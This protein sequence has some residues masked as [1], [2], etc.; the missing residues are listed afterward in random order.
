MSNINDLNNNVESTIMIEISKYLNKYPNYYKKTADKEVRP[1]HR[2]ISDCKENELTFAKQT[3]NKGNWY[4]FCNIVVEDVADLWKENHY[5]SEV[6]RTEEPIKCFFDLDIIEK[7]EEKALGY[8]EWEWIRTKLIY[9]INNIDTGVRVKKDDFV[10]SYS[11]GYSN[12]KKAI[13]V[14]YHIVILNYW[15]KNMVDFKKFITQLK[16]NMK[17]CS[18]ASIIIDM[19]DWGIV[20]KNQVFKLPYQSKAEDDNPDRIQKPLD[21]KWTVYDFLVSIR[22]QATANT[23]T[24]FYDVSKC[25]DEKKVMTI[26][27]S[28]NKTITVGS[29]DKGTT[30]KNYQSAIAKYRGDVFADLIEPRIKDCFKDSPEYYLYSI[31]NT[32]DVGYDLWSMVGMCLKTIYNKEEYSNDERGLELWAEWTSSYDSA[33]KSSSLRSQWNSFSKNGWGFPTIKNIAQL[34]NYKIGCNNDLIDVLFRFEK[35]PTWDYIECNTDKLGLAINVEEL[36]NAYNVLYIKSP[37]ATGKSYMLRKIYEREPSATVLVL[38][39]KRSFASSMACELGKYGF[40]NYD[41][42]EYKYNIKDHD[43]IICSVESLYHCRDSYDYLIIDE[44]ETIATNLVGEMNMKG[45]PIKNMEKFY[46]LVNNCKNVFVM[47][48]YLFNRSRDMI[49]DI[50]QSNVKSVYI[51]NVYKFPQRYVKQFL[52]EQDFVDDMDKVL[53]NKDKEIVFVSNGLRKQ[54][55]IL[56]NMKSKPSV[57]KYNARCP[58]DKRLDVNKEWEG[59]NL[60]TY[61]PTITAG[62]SCDKKPKDVLYLYTVNQGSCLLR[63]TIQASKRV[64]RFNNNNIRLLIGHIPTNGEIPQTYREVAESQN[65]FIESLSKDLNW[66]K[67]C[68]ENVKLSYIVK[69]LLWCKL[70]E[71]LNIKCF[72]ALQNRFFEEENIKVLDKYKKVE[73]DL[74]ERWSDDLELKLDKVDDIDNDEYNEICIMK[75]DSNV[76]DDDDFRK[77]L[78]YKYLN[79]DIAD[80]LSDE[81]K[82]NVFEEIGMKENRDVWLKSISFKKFVE[83]VLDVENPEEIKQK[84]QDTIMNWG[85]VGDKAEIQQKYLIRWNYLL[86]IFNDMG[87]VKDKRIEMK[88]I[89]TQDYDKLIEKFKTISYRSL[90]QIFDDN[91]LRISNV[92]DDKIVN[93]TTKQMHSIF[94]NLLDECLGLTLDK[95]GRKKIKGRENKIY[96]FK[97]KFRDI[98]KPMSQNYYNL[99]KS[100]FIEKKRYKIK[101]KSQS[102]CI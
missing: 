75:E 45:Y 74:V 58:L 61:T 93:F 65:N 19:I 84:I 80:G 52:R 91:N 62:V 9:H 71:N 73:K 81:V 72:H 77:Y 51:N 56:L 30:M 36:V 12:T 44:S 94:N 86:Q 88:P 96:D 87:F 2:A 68:E 57:L 35:K 49:V 20:K 18:K 60:L 31:P 98:S 97:P 6:I 53:E 37:M 67:S 89:L 70:E 10:A 24:V 83:T 66:L 54:E 32:V 14:S 78:K 46:H 100:K 33:I 22:G 69:I 76:L 79:V 85:K 43:R 8:Y 29:W 15:F 55:Q 101:R 34:H 82:S 17:G 38:S 4:S 92:I 11:R 40:E 41:N 95:I 47:D 50:M 26:K 99:I 7:D 102:K 1:L 28:T 90:K 5:L 21:D 39:C 42:L 3:K 59:I 25:I 64:R 27:T 63:D 13:K 23:P 16:D 48:A